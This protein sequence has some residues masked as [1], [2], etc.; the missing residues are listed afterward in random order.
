MHHFSKNKITCTGVTQSIID[1]WPVWT[2]HTQNYLPN[3]QLKP[4]D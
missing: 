3:Q 2:I 4:L 1:G